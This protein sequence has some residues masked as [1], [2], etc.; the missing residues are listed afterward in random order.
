MVRVRVGKKRVIIGLTIVI[1]ITIIA[2]LG[3]GRIKVV[4]ANKISS[5]LELGIK[6]LTEGKYDKAKEEF[7]RVTSIDNTHEEAIK[8]MELIDDYLKL[9]NLYKK[10][11]Y[12]SAL[13]LINKINENRYLKY[14]EEKVNELSVYIEEKIKIINEINNIDGQI[15]KLISENKYEEAISLING[16]LEQDLEEE[17]SNKL[18]TLMSKVNDS[19]RSYDEEQKRI[20]IEEERKAEEERK[21]QEEIAKQ[22]AENKK[23]ESSTNSESVNLGTNEVN[24]G[25]YQLDAA[26][27]ALQVVRREHP[28]YGPH[29]F[30]RG[31]VTEG[32]WRWAFV[33]LKLED[34][35]AA[36]IE[37]SNIIGQ[38]GYTVNAKTG[39][40]KQEDWL[41]Q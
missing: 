23:E 25:I 20:A 21:K 30:E 9:E 7:L 22:E 37:D 6:Y 3:I 4:N 10:K 12:V 40:V 18:N 34:S 26:E 17:Y 2:T 28:G 16:Y 39:E 8:L 38:V 35:N 41:V 36:S 24:E 5:S 33:F 29:Y 1:A 31:L 15:D 32:E 14:I 11:E 27:M 19:K 13:D